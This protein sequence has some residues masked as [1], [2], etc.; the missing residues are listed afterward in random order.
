MTRRI[1]EVQATMDTRILDVS[2][3]HGRKFFAQICAML[4]FDIFN[5]GIPAVSVFSIEEKIDNEG[6]LARTIPRC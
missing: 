5:D 2:V 6:D 1:D 4:V 3:T